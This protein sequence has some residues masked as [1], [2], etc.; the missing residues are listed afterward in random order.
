[1]KFHDGTPFTSQAVKTTVEHLL[2]SGT[3]SSRR[4]SY[5]LIKDVATPD[6]GTVRIT[7]DP[8]TPDLPFLMADGSIRIISPAALTKFGKDLGRNPVGTGPFK[9][10]EWIPGQRVV[11]ETFPDY[12]GPRP[13][14][15]RWIYRPIPEAAGRVVALKTG[16]ADVVLNIPASDIEGLKA[17]TNVTLNVA[18]SLT[19]IEAEPRQSK[20]PFNDVKVRYALNQSIDKD[21]IIANV[22]RGA[23]LPLRTPSIP[24]L[25][26]TFDFD[27][28]PFDP[29]KAKALLAEAGFPNGFEATI[30]YVSGRWSGDDQVAEAMQG[31][32][33]NI[34]I[35]TTIVKIQSAELVPQLSADPDTMAGT[36]FLVLKTS[37]Y[38]DYH[39]YRMYHSDATTK[40]VTAQ[41]YAYGNPEVDK[42]LDEQRQTFDPNK[43]LPLLQKAEELIWKDMPLVYLAHQ[44]NVWGQRKN[45]SG[46]KFLPSNSVWPGT[47]QKS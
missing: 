2:D 25:Y 8:P 9:F 13:G 30:R 12:W 46:F 3:G 5:T 38:V 42:L 6:D 28:P 43:R 22:L 21:A 11:L 27:P 16:E 32:W 45:V 17:D 33:N 7:T 29:A 20:P 44:S 24:G 41:R 4:A 10:A 47:V 31:F 40:T 14:V 37:E 23:A 39:L 36:V 34:G 18:P 19:I 1:V 15:R 35:K 26:G